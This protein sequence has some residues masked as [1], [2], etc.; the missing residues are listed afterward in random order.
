[1]KSLITALFAMLVICAVPASLS[2][3]SSN[4]PLTD[5]RQDVIRTNLVA[6]LENS[7]AEV[8]ASYMQLVIDLKRAY[9]EYDFDYAI[10]PLMSILKNEDNCPMRMLAALALYEFEDSRMSRF[11]VL[12]TFYHCDS[13]RLTKHCKTLVLKWHQR[14]DRPVYTAEVVY[15]F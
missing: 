6:G 7:S 14:D 1:M 5:E 11:A 2:A 8:R 9:P 15:P 4:P 12:Q 13:D 3:E 10:I